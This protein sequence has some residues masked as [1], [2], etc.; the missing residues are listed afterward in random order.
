MSGVIYSDCLYPVF[1]DKLNEQLAS[2]L[3]DYD[4]NGIKQMIENVA[5]QFMDGTDSMHVLVKDFYIKE[6]SQWLLSNI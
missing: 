6:L 4:L 1:I 3:I 2:G 5:L